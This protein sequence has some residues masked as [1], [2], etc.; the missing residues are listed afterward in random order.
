MQ[1]LH[2]LGTGY[3][4]ENKGNGC[5]DRIRTES[6]PDGR[7]VMA[8][9]DGCSSS[10][11]AE[12][13]SQSNVDVICNI[14][15]NFNIDSLSFDAFAKMYPELKKQEEKLSDD[16]AG[17]FSYA[18]QK[19][20]Y[21]D[22]RKRYFES[23]DIISASDYCATLL[24]AV[25]EE[26]KT[27][28]GHIG[29]GNVICFNKKGKVV[30]RSKEDNGE[31]STHTYFTVSDNFRKHFFYDVIPSDDI[32]CIV[33]FSDGPQNM[34]KCEYGDIEKGVREIVAKPILNGRIC[35]DEALAKLFEKYIGQAK[36]YVS[37]DWSMVIA[38]N[39]KKIVRN[40]S[41]I[42]LNGIFQEEFKKIKFD[43]F[44]NIIEDGRVR[45]DEDNK[46]DDYGYADNFC[47]DACLEKVD[48]ELD[49]QDTQG[50]ESNN[51]SRKRKKLS[52]GFVFRKNDERN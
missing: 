45:D 46:Q 22:A 33:M 27:C 15:R 17:C 38:Y 48:S 1:L 50:V 31:D 11:C 13:A 16:L 37:D 35:S 2:L 26:K 39:G 32:A 10:K 42:S 51:K 41:P 19:P 21:A 49:K 18:L 34:F 8:V 6:Y 47:T 12:V 4:H 20:L 9:S 23:G 28:I 24:F 25:R 30:Y 44:G 40:I 3:G 36:H 5:Q 14:F 52:R 43:E 29:D 7:I